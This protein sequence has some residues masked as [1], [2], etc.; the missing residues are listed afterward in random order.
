M[1]KRRGLAHGQEN[2]QW[3]DVGSEHGGTHLPG[4][5][6][7]QSWK[8]THTNSYKAGGDSK[9]EFELS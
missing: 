1:Y 7:I 4:K 5:K 8:E 9:L 3:H 2:Y 6:L